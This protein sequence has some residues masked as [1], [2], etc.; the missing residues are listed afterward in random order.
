M[1]P[2]VLDSDMAKTV[3]EYVNN[4]GIELLCDTAVS[5]IF[6]G[7]FFEGIRSPGTEIRAGLGIL[8]T[9]FRPAVGMAEDAGLKTGHMGIMVSPS[10]E[11]SF[12]DIY[13]AGDCVT[14]WSVTDGKPIAAKLATSA[15]K[16]GAVAGIN[17]AGGSEEYHGSAGTFVTKIGELEVAGTGFSSE[18][19]RERGYETVNGKIKTYQLP[20]YFPG[21]DEISIKIIA[22][23][24]SGRILGG[25][26]VGKSGAAAR[27]NIISMAVELG[28]DL[29]S[30]SRLEMAYCP[31]VSEVDDP[32]FKAVDFCI[33]RMK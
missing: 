12:A 8:S 11:T 14:C 3:E 1:L 30:L 6:G 31:A 28:L 4:L 16:Q 27:I 32:L 17:A 26:A 2:G 23:K 7:D 9:G 20:E 29:K 33:R 5:E 15:Y 18:Q 22:D 24:G 10:M 13:A 21:G 25:Q 19:C